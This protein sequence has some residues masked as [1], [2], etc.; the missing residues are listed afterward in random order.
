MLI[1]AAESCLVECPGVAG[2]LR[3]T[4]PPH[5]E[6]QGEVDIPERPR[7]PEFSEGIVT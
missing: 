7:Q 6:G 2:S 4:L 5:Q 3:G 1:R